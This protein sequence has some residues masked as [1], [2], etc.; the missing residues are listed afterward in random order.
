[1]AYKGG[2]LLKPVTVDYGSVGK[3]YLQGINAVVQTREKVLE[4]RATQSKNLT[5]A[6]NYAATGLHDMDRML[7]DHGQNVS[8]ELAE[9]QRLNDLG[10]ISRREVAAIHQRTVAE[11]QAL[12]Q[13]NDVMA[14]NIEALDKD[15][16]KS[17]LSK[18][19]LTNLYFK[20]VNYR[21]FYK[22]PN[23]GEVRDLK[24]AFQIKR[25]DGQSFMVGT[26]QYINPS[27][28]QVENVTI[29]KPLVKMIDP[30]QHKW[31]KVDTDAID[32]K[33]KGF[34]DRLGDK[35]FSVA[36]PDGIP[37]NIP[38]EKSQIIGNNGEVIV[39][40][41][42]SDPS[43]FI[44]AVESHIDSQDRK[45]YEAYAYEQMGARA[46]WHSGY[47][48]PLSDK[49]VQDRFNK[50]YVD[51]NGDLLEVTKDPTQ[52]RFNEEGDIFL[53]DDTLKVVKA[54]YRQQIL[55]SLDVR[56]ED[57]KI[58][59]PA[60]LEKEKE[61]MNIS[62]AVYNRV[63][64]SGNVITTGFDRD[65]IKSNYLIEFGIVNA[66]QYKTVDLSAAR[67][68]YNRQGYTNALDLLYRDVETNQGKN[69]LDDSI[70][71]LLF[72]EDVMEYNGVSL[73]PMKKR[74]T[75]ALGDVTSFTGQKF[76]SI[77]A[78]TVVEISGSKPQI[79]LHGT[80][81]AGKVKR[82]VPGTKGGV[83]I[84]RTISEDIPAATSSPLA[85][86]QARRL[87]RELWKIPAAREY[88]SKKKDIKGQNYTPNSPDYLNALASFA[89]QYKI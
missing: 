14:K 27:N 6:T 78:F 60:D 41:K 84:E 35:G 55:A 16:T 21:G 13:L 26:Y 65:H 7:L 69:V 30:S 15:D 31:D 71:Y 48:G 46:P 20:D 76:D 68:D 49:Q 42:I 61:M 59:D 81:S 47:S 52:F 62:G 9:A 37:I 34:V 74:I 38:Y 24:Q 17:E 1:M 87:Y 51:A 29:K 40:N 77:N 85:E 79:I 67:A 23:T 28:N 70:Q 33:I 19:Q 56:T 57:Y 82:E 43:Q 54:H 88:F 3:M 39:Y 73:D 63:D 83:E 4:E 11:S 53:D 32:K 64:A 72:S 12:G 80:A 58:K 18:D 45:F 66:D 36:G 75:D 5:D 10:L 8:M 89:Q 22:D 25:I 86:Q 2:F 50:R 44:P